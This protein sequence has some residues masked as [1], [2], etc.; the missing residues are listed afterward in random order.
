MPRFSRISWKSREEAEPPRIP[1]RS[2]AAKRRRSEREIPGAARQKWYCS[3]SLRWNRRPGGGAFTSGRRTRGPFGVG[4]SSAFICA[5]LSS[6]SSSSCF[7]FPAAATTTLP[8]KYIARW[9]DVIALRLVLVHRNL[10]EH[11]L[12]LRVEVGE[13]RR[14]HHLPHHLERD[15]EPLVRDAREHHR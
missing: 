15:P 11:D 14:E 4:A 3:V 5:R 12:A 8:G 7:T 1:S 13:A 2:E 9:Y 6:R 10:L